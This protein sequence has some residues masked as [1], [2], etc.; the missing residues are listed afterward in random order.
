MSLRIACTAKRPFSGESEIC[1]TR[2]PARLP[3]RSSPCLFRVFGGRGR[4]FD[5]AGAKLR[6]AMLDGTPE[7]IRQKM[8]VMRQSRVLP[9]LQRRG[10]EF[11]AACP[12]GRRSAVTAIAPSAS[13]IALPPCTHP[14]AIVRV[15]VHKSKDKQPRTSAAAMHMPRVHVQVYV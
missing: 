7:P 12:D 4:A 8:S 14:A 6:I 2:W 9:M 1:F 3:V 10:G 5:A 11:A 15:Q 13:K